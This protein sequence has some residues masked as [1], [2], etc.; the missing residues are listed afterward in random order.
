MLGI[1]HSRGPVTM[2]ESPWDFKY[3]NLNEFCYCKLQTEQQQP[4][5]AFINMYGLPANEIMVK[6]RSK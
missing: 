3:G 4:A 5:A 6:D 1:L 2:A